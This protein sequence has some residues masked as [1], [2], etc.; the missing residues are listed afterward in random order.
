MLVSVITAV[1][2]G[3]EYLQECIDSILNQTYVDFEY[4][5]VNDGSS[6]GTKGILDKITDNRV[7]VIHSERNQGAAAS[8]N[9]GI[10][11][12]KGKWIAIQDADDIS[13]PMRLEKQM[14]YLQK[15]PDVIGVS[16]LIKSISGKESVSVDH[17]KN[18][19]HSYNIQLSKEKIRSQCLHSCYVCHGT[20]VYSKEAFNKVGKY[21]TN[22][23]ISY[24]YDLWVR[25]FRIMPIEKLPEVLY[26]YRI[27]A[28]SLTNSN[29][30]RVNKELLLIATS[31][32][33]R[34]V[35][36]NIKRKPRFVIIGAK[37]GCDFFEKDIAPNID[38]EIYNFTNINDRRS[39]PK[40]IKLIKQDKIDAVVVMNN[41][42]AANCIRRLERKG[43]KINEHLFRIWSF[44][45]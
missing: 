37:E 32:A 41:S 4:I 18:I 7:T 9:V 42:G 2:N 45:G 38:I 24:D 39:E 8:L 35:H 26:E 23:K 33:W 12:A 29:P 28:N 43:L 16:A 30:Q 27:I 17:I 3:E 10:E 21:N 40:I 15:N 5:I 19:E 31:H 44:W 1:Y 34:I 14:K 11:R 36:N 22:Y 20:V 13:R 25:L 6:D